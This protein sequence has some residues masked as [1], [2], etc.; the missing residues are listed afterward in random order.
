MMSFSRTPFCR[1]W[2]GWLLVGVL[3]NA[4]ILADSVRETVVDLIRQ[5]PPKNIVERLTAVEQLLDVGAF[6]EANEYLQQVVAAK[7]SP[8]QWAAAQQEVGSP[9][10][11]R[12][13]RT[14][15]VAELGAQ[16]ARLISEGTTAWSRDP[17]RI[18]RAIDSI[19]SAD[20]DTRIQ[21]R[22]ELV[23]L[24][25]LAAAA[26]L[27]RLRDPKLAPAVRTAIQDA[28]ARQ[29]QSA[30][31]PLVAALAAEERAVAD[32]VGPR[33]GPPGCGIGGALSAAT[34]SRCL[35]VR[36]S[37]CGGCHGDSPDTWR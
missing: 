20:E 30:V 22:A 2:L 6:D 16:V 9:L 25:P 3:T 7:L 35:V 37:P 4:T 12:L 34:E 5:S 29:G 36:G 11:V 10:I 15:Q 19:T 1:V 32:R 18:A 13:I 24:G 8:Q 33:A 21:A 23:R 26:M 27:E 28:L 14:P 17:Q 31:P